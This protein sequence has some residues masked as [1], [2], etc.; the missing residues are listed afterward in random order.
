[1]QIE[2]E[3]QEEFA[4]WLKVMGQGSIWIVVAGTAAEAL[5]LV[6]DFIVW[7]INKI[8]SCMKKNNQVKPH[9]AQTK[10]GPSPEKLRSEAK[11]K[12]KVK[13]IC[14][15]DKVKERLAEKKK[16]LEMKNKQK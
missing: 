1:M 13:I 10:K 11:G 2:D 8:S 12:D 4:D 15:M 14:D 9:N 5:F 3:F 6:I 16:Q 7:T